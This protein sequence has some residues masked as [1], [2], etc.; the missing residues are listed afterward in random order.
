MRAM[1]HPVPNVQHQRHDAW[2]VAS[3]ST[4]PS[5]RSQLRLASARPALNQLHGAHTA[6]CVVDLPSRRNALRSVANS[7]SCVATSLGTKFCRAALLG[8]Q[9]RSSSRRKGACIG[10]FNI[11]AQ[12]SIAV[13]SLC[14]SSRPSVP[15]QSGPLSNNRF[16]PT[17][18]RRAPVGPRARG[19]AAAQP[20]R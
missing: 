13:K 9:L 8:A 16:V 7:P 19:A 4:L 20:E 1:L 5:V 14:L 6:P 10:G 17:A 3:V 11:A 12:R 15:A 18:N 2:P